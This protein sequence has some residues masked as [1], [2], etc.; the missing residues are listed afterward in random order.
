MN[1]LMKCKRGALAIDNLVIIL[2]LIGVMVAVLIVVAYEN[3][4][5]QG[6][7]IPIR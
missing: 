1:N 3:N 5:L 4:W 7:D 6:V 2:I